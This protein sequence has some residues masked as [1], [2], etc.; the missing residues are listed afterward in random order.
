M[1]R[2]GIET[3]WKEPDKYWK[4]LYTAPRP[5]R[6]KALNPAR[7]KAD[8]PPGKKSLLLKSAAE[9]SLRLLPVL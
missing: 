4:I 9:D 3:L 8:V 6:R 2:K 7:I 5:G 1:K